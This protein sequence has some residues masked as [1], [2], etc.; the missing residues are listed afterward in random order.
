MTASNKNLLSKPT[1]EPAKTREQLQISNAER[2]R[3]F[4]MRG[5]GEPFGAPF[6]IHTLSLT[7]KVVKLFKQRGFFGFATLEKHQ[8]KRKINKFTRYAAARFRGNYKTPPKD[9]Q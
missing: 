5:G 7:E 8:K 3:D 2:I 9:L 6:E 1:N 4:I